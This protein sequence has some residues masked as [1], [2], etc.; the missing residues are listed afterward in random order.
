MIQALFVLAFVLALR[1]ST[2]TWRHLPLRYV[3][4][5]IIAIGSVYVYSF[6]GLIWLGGNSSHLGGSRVGW[7]NP[8]LPRVAR[9]GGSP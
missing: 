1:E 5:A 4:A 3:P 7:A 8:R 6:P 2:R 9:R